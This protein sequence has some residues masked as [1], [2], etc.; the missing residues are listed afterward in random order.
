MFLL[1]FNIISSGVKH[2]E[3]VDAIVEVVGVASVEWG[4]AVACQEYHS[5]VAH[6]LTVVVA[7]HDEVTHHAWQAVVAQVSRNT[8][9]AKVGVAKVVIGA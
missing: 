8:S 6:W 2:L 3:S 5:G 1:H 4:G 7:K 9:F